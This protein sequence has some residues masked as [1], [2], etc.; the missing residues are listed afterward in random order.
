MLCNQLLILS[1]LSMSA[2]IAL[3]VADIAMIVLA[4]KIQFLPLPQLTYIMIKLQL[5]WDPASLQTLQ[6]AEV[7]GMM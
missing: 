5:R 1:P 2:T 4:M 6:V 3:S 7:E